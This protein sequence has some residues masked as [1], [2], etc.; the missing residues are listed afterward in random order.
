MHL[1]IVLNNLMIILM[2]NAYARKDIMKIT[3]IKLVNNAR[4]FGLNIFKKILLQ[5]INLLK[6]LY[7]LMIIRLYALHALIN[8]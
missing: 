8:L 6:V 5:K 2:D 4:F 1:L 7:A 3:K